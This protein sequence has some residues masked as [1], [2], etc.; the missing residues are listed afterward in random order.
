MRVSAD[1][2]ASLPVAVSGFSFK[3]VGAFLLDSMKGLRG[4][5]ASLGPGTSLVQD[6]FSAERTRD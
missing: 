6:P 3:T 2:Q 1:N 5:I 4:W